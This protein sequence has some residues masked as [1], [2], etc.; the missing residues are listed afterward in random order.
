MS[1]V[2]IHPKNTG[3][4]RYAKKSS[5]DW[6][7]TDKEPS[8]ADLATSKLTPW[9]KRKNPATTT[10]QHNTYFFKNI[11][12]IVMRNSFQALHKQVCICKSYR[13]LTMP[14]YLPWQFA[15]TKFRL[16]SGP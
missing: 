7:L 5:P 2:I 14:P 9:Q 15:M 13:H 11:I 12:S 10:N 3:L 8:P 1:W 6:L 16:T 4:P